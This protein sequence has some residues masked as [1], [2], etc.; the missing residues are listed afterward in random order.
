MRKAVGTGIR[1]ATLLA[2]LIVLPVSTGWVTVLALTGIVVVL[3]G[4]CCLAACC[5]CDPCDCDCPG[6]D[7]ACPDDCC[8]DCDCDCDCGCDD[9]DC[10][11][12][13]CCDGCDCDCGCAV[14][15]PETAMALPLMA[16]GLPKARAMALD[17]RLAHHPATAAYDQDVYRLGAWRFCIGC[18]TVY[19]V[20]LVAS[21][22]LA[23][24]DVGGTPAFW[25]LLGTGL[26]LAQLV[27]AAG[28]ARRRWQ[29]ALVKTCL[30]TGLAAVFH[31]VL[32]SSLSPGA[33]TA[34][35]LGVLVAAFAT[36]IPRALRMRCTHP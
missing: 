11:C 15:G 5:C 29:K 4:L 24:G 31:G 1:F 33:Q 7:C 2:F 32:V 25:I 13:G 19:P 14:P 26:A 35:L 18:T 28:K 21:L 20:F 16:W 12:D 8:G 6:C 34:V 27:S 30:G 9:C 23:F 10:G 36:A 22:I 3:S 17:R